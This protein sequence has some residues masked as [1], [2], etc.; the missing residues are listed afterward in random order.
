MLVIRE[1]RKLLSSKN[2]EFKFTPQTQQLAVTDLGSR[3]G[4][5]KLVI[6]MKQI[7]EW[8]MG[9]ASDYWVQPV[10]QPVMFEIHRN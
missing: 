8:G 10:N 6:D 2:S 7:P 9:E 3:Y 5:A 4:S 1:R